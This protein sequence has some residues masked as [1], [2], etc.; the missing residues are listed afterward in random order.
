MAAVSV[1]GPAFRLGE[2]ELLD[3]VAPSAVQAAERLSRELGYG[4]S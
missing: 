1:S 3:A 2:R 4:A